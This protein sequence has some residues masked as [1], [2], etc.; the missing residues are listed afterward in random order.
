MKDIEH[1]VDGL[2]IESIDSSIDSTNLR[3]SSIF[4]P[5]S[6]RNLILYNIISIHGHGKKA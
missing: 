3:F 1:M 2:P 6:T 5:S 4:K